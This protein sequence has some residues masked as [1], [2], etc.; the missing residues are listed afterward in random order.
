MGLVRRARMAG[1]TAVG[2]LGLLGLVVSFVFCPTVRLINDLTLGNL[3]QVTRGVYQ[4]MSLF[5]RSML[6][7][8]RTA[9]PLILVVSYPS[10]LDTQQFIP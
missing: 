5:Q 10:Q 4:I 2:V 7:H 6:S 9:S 1:R 3:Q 8:Y